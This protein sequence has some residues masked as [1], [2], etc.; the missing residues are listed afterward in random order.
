ML[1]WI[2][3]FIFG[4]TF[5]KSSKIIFPL[6]RWECA[7]CSWSSKSTLTW[8]WDRLLLWFQVD[9][10]FLC[11]IWV[12]LG[13]WFSK[14]VLGNSLEM[15]ICRAWPSWTRNT[16]T[17]HRPSNLCF[18]VS[19]DWFWCMQSFENQCHK[20]LAIKPNALVGSYELYLSLQ[21]YKR[22]FLLNVEEFLVLIISHNCD[23]IWKV[24]RGKVL[25]I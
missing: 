21:S 13:Q 10:S 12:N 24:L 5:L 3:E 2:K 11:I 19:S 6:G 22:H 8:A 14:V 7:Y 23:W 20:N 18:N 4:F 16:N 17:G 15:H 9:F 25:L 1:D